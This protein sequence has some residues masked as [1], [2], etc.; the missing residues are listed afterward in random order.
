[1][2]KTIKEICCK[3]GRYME[4]TQDHVQRWALTL[5]V[6]NLSVSL[7]VFDEGVSLN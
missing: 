4:L 5:A 6:L 3:D 2:W 1:M 7:K